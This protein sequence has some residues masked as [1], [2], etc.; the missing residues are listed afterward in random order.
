MEFKQRHLTKLLKE[1]ITNGETIPA[2]DI[3]SEGNYYLVQI[4]DLYN[5]NIE[6]NT[7]YLSKCQVRTS[8]KKLSK[9]DILIN[10]VSI[11]PSGVGK[12]V[13][14]NDLPDSM[15]TI[16]E[17]N[18]FRLRFNND[19]ILPKYFAYYAN[20]WLYK[21]QILRFAKTTNQASIS[22][23]DLKDIVILLPDL[24]YQEYTLRLLAHWDKSIE[25]QEKLIEKKEILLKQVTKDLIFGQIRIDSG[26]TK[27]IE[28]KYG[29]YAA[30]WDFV[31]VKTIA[32]EI[33]SVNGDNEYTVFSC[34]KYDGLVPSLEY[35]GR[36]IYSDDTSNYK[37][38]KRNQFAYAT[39]HIEE[40]SIGYQNL[41]DFGLVSPMY[42]VFATSDDVNDIY[43][44]RVLKTE[45]Y[46]HIFEINTSGTV[47][48]RGS[49]RWSEFSKIKV[50]LPPIEEQ[51]QIV[52]ILKTFE[53]ELDL[54]KQ[55]LEL[56]K[57]QKEGLMQVLLTGKVRV[58][59]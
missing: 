1:P 15:P 42:T 45:R 4:S 46:R 28:T 7:E 8:S 49:L 53:N 30:D 32:K 14:V 2:D 11:K 29:N 59:A 9:E 55:K 47:N 54:Q 51:S 21:K 26:K 22:Q 48:R 34:T 10:R 38:V 43:L 18:M 58:K 33:N 31:K 20:S 44:Y 36:Q 12:A 37:I 17:S 50:P 13:L 25:L 56:L 41:M 35:F 16:L 3:G 23:E 5:S 57:L 40:G 39:N 52:E 6:L 24:Y 19:A 27:F